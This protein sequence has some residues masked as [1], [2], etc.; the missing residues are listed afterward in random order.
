MQIFITVLIIL[1]V[2]FIVYKNIKKVSAGS[3]SC[4]GSCSAKCPKLKNNTCSS[5]INFKDKK[6]PN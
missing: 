6:T 2:V 3:C 1:L 5:N 4:D